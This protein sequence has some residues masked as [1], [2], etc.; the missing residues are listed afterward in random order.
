V[1]DS[2]RDGRTPERSAERFVQHAHAYLG[3][4]DPACL[5]SEAGRRGHPSGLAAKIDSAQ[6]CL[7]TVMLRKA[8]AVCLM[9]DVTQTFT[10]L[11]GLGGMAACAACHP[12]CGLRVTGWRADEWLQQ[13]R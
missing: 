6:L 9:S 10:D 1:T 8:A 7:V 12:F 4:S 5:I 3:K 2:L 11:G 13:T